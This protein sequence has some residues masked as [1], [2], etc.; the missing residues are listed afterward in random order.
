[1]IKARGA[2]LLFHLSL[3]II[4]Y[5]PFDGG[6]LAVIFLVLLGAS[7]VR[8]WLWERSGLGRGTDQIGPARRRR[9]FVFGREVEETGLF[10]TEGSA[11]RRVDKL[12]FERKCSIAALV[13]VTLVLFGLL[14]G[15]SV[16]KLAFPQVLII[17]AFSH[18]LMTAHT[19][20]DTQR[21]TFISM[22]LYF[23]FMVFGLN[24]HWWMHSLWITSLVTYL[25]SNPQ[26]SLE[27]IFLGSTGR[28]ILVH[29]FPMIIMFTWASSYK[30]ETGPSEPLVK[31]IARKEQR[32]KNILADKNGGNGHQ[33]SRLSLASPVVNGGESIENGESRESGSSNNGLLDGSRARQRGGRYSGVNPKGQSSSGSEFDGS[34]TVVSRSDGKAFSRGSQESGESN[35][36]GELDPEGK[37]GA[38]QP[39]HKPPEELQEIEKKWQRRM[40]WLEFNKKWLVLL[41]LVLIITVWAVVRHRNSKPKKGVLKK[42]NPDDR[43][44]LQGYFKG[45]WSAPLNPAEEVLRFYYGL[46]RAMAMVDLG[47]PTYQPA[48]YHRDQL[49]EISPAIAESLKTIIP[50]YYDVLHGHSVPTEQNLQRYRQA[51]KSFLRDIGL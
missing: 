44:M 27:P 5:R 30:S 49:Q 2:V 22:S 18:L 31:Q 40:D 33:S 39:S 3:T 6:V 45:L 41:G 34:S 11:K 8:T 1:M 12:Y 20:R 42:L 50:I 28:R 16:F 32:L 43:K 25:A 10:E 47:R 48:L 23:I 15:F 36:I 9:I 14:A 13:Y 19:R 7:F 17:S 21:I 29:S 38:S 46:E 4:C 26:N 24:R 37:P 35:D 51:V